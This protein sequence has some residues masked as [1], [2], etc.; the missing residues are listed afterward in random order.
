MSKK[1]KL[2]RLIDLC[3]VHFAGNK[4]AMRIV[5]DAKEVLKNKKTPKPKQALAYQLC[6]DY[7]LKDFHPGWHFGAVQGNHIK[8]IINKIKKSI[9]ADGRDVS[10]E[11]IFNTFKAILQNMDEWFKDKDLQVI[12]SKY[13]EIIEQIRSRRPAHSAF[14]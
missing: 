1:K 3:E 9:T 10:D 14:D 8:Q 13:N 12:N 4:E 2:Q 5:S 7:W 11:L 6:V